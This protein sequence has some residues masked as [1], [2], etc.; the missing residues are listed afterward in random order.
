MDGSNVAITRGKLVLSTVA[1]PAERSVPVSDRMVR[2]TKPIALQPDE[3]A[4][5]EKTL[6]Y[7]SGIRGAVANNIVLSTNT[8]F[9]TRY[10][11]MIRGL[12]LM[13]MDDF[14]HI[15]L[16][17]DNIRTIRID[18]GA[19]TIKLDIWRAG[20][21]SKRRKKRKRDKESITSAYDLSSVDRRDRRCLAQ[22]LMRLNGLDD[23]ECQ[24]DLTIDT[25]QP[26][27]Y[28]L[29]MSI[30]D[31]ITVQSLKNVLHECRS[32]CTTF[33]FD[34]PHKIVRAKCLR[35]AAPL[36]RRVLKLKN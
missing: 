10:I 17:N 28:R 5:I 21:S 22:L 25:S 27:A 8:K 31:P 7:I 1:S 11:I 32:F 16:M 15:L 13:T 36:K 20:H 34:F 29:D 12:P 19:E 6:H 18:M 14:E 23:I 33:E 30:F 24:F 35:L 26:E 2:V 3:Q 9:P 4:F